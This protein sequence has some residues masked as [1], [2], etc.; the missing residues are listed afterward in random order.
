MAFSDLDQMNYREF[1]F[2][3][4][5][6]QPDLRYMIAAS[7]RSGS[8]WL[9]L[10]LWNCGGGGAPWEYFNE[11]YNLG[12]L[13]VRFGAKTA[14][15]YLAAL[16]RHRVSENGVFG[17]KVLTPQLPLFQTCLREAGDDVSAFKIIFL[18]RRDKIRQA[19]SYARA[20][21][22]E[23]WSSLANERRTSDY[24]P[25]L[26]KRSYVML[27][28]HTAFW[29]QVFGALGTKPLVV[30]YEDLEAD[31]EHE[32]RR[33][34]EYLE[35]KLRIGNVGLPS[36]VRQRD[37]VTEEW[38]DRFVAEEHAWLSARFTRC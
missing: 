5:D 11:L 33:I 6:R 35:I 14:T 24:N 38:A 1:D 28:K 29:R 30:F 2:K 9:A 17:V 13:A 20:V 12:P 26:L 27:W 16:Y 36:L 22:T 15:E 32:V 18:D 34:E 10:K 31:I 25:V 21:Q 19:I 4:R 37:M 3:A 23:Q 7:H 8:T